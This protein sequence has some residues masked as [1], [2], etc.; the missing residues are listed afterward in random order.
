MNEE[1]KS[2]P[3]CGAEKDFLEIVFRPPITVICAYV[4]CNKCEAMG[5]IARHSH[6]GENEDLEMKAKEFWNKRATEFVSVEGRPYPI[7]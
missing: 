5:G 3:F 6:L 1:L 2:C 4:Q 7:E